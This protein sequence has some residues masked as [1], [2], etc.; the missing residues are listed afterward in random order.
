MGQALAELVDP[1][2]SSIQPSPIATTGAREFVWADPVR[3]RQVVRNLITNARRYGGDHIAVDVER[4]ADLVA[5]TVLDDGPGVPEDRKQAIF[6]PYERGQAQ[7]TQPGSVGLGLTVS[8]ELARM[9]G[10]D[11]TL[12]RRD[13]MTRFEITVPAFMEDRSRLDSVREPV[14]ANVSVDSA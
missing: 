9:M 11:L 1:G 10:G 13:E 8:R 3:L 7:S 6:E 14:A 4:R 12:E 2:P 5:I